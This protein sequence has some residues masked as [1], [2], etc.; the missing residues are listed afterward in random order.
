MINRK[1][2]FGLCC[3]MFAFGCSDSGG[4]DIPTPSDKTASAILEVNNNLQKNMVLQQNS[5]FMVAGRGTPGQY[6]TIT[7]SWNKANVDEVEVDQ[8][9]RWSKSIRIPAGSF[10]AQAIKVSGK[11]SF[12]FNDI[13]I[14]EV[15]LCS[16]QSNM[17]YP[18]KEVLGGLDEI[19]K[20]D[21][22][23]GV[24]LLNLPQVQADA[25]TDKWNATWQKCS[26]SSLEWFSAVGYYFAKQL[27]QSLQVPIGIINASWGDTTGE[28]WAERSAVLAT[29]SVREFALQQDK[30]PRA[31]PFSPYKIGAA[32]NAMIYPIR[33]IPIAGAIWYQGEAN[34][35][36]PS[37][38][39]DLLETVADSWRALW[40]KEANDFPFYIAQ[41]CPYKR[42]YNFQ[43]NYANPNMRFAQLQASKRIANSG[44]ICNDD[45]A[46]LDDIHPKNKKDVGLRFAYLAL[47]AHYKKEDGDRSP[48]FDGFTV[49]GN[50]LIVDFQFA[51]TGL[52]TKD[53]LA[54]SQFEIAGVDKVF[55]PADAVIAGNKVLLTSSRVPHP[56]AAR[57]GWSYTKISNLVGSSGLPVSVFKTYAWADPEEEG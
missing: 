28:V 32:Y 10:E 8:E 15:W 29:P 3:W 24:R 41:I 12:E 16:G 54:P 1:I 53:G 50:K 25:P 42:M 45:I 56:I 17:W 2:F 40:N 39:P 55:Y 31:D 7:A 20:A 22:S 4:Q 5:T 13:L 44:I 35:D 48:I 46:D 43:T 9:G 49:D 47:A 57:L 51:S 33:D 6:V 36:N 30:Q 38:Y 52:K 27:R 34:M 23:N 37:Y 19:V 21:A 18:M 14:G 11:N 26:P